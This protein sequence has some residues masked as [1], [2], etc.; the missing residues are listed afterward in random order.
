MPLPAAVRRVPP[1]TAADAATWSGQASKT[2]EMNK[3]R[4]AGDE[5]LE[6]SKVH[7][8]KRQNVH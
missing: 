4:K 6:D 7:R 1:A 5:D 3:L 2:H 8:V